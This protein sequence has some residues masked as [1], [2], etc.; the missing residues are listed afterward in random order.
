MAAG[1]RDI[2]LVLTTLPD[3][4]TATALA[5][6][7]VEQRLAACVNIL[8]ECTSMYRWE[9]EVKNTI[10]VPLLIKTSCLTYEALERKIRAHHPYELPEILRVPASGLPAYL[11]WVNRESAAG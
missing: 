7:L 1:Q 8:A 3:R 6:L 4:A 10:E 9:G 5:Q 2:L 11:A